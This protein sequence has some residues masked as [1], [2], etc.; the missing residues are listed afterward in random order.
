MNQDTLS[1]SCPTVSVASL[2]S[3]HF[4]LPSQRKLVDDDT[5]IAS[6]TQSSTDTES[7]MSSS[8]ASIQRDDDDHSLNH[9]IISSSTKC[10]RSRFRVRGVKRLI[11][12]LMH[13]HGGS[14]RHPRVAKLIEKLET[15]NP[16]EQ[17]AKSHLLL[18]D[19]VAH[20]SPD[21]PGRIRRRKTTSNNNNNNSSS[22]SGGSNDVGLDENTKDEDDRVVQYALGRLSFGI[23]QPNHLVC[24][25]RSVRNCIQI[26]DNEE[27]QEECGVR[28]RR[29]FHYPIIIDLTIHTPYGDLLAELRHEALC[30]ETPNNDTR[31]GVTFLGG[32]LEPAYAVWSDPHLLEL[33]KQTFANAYKIA[34]EQRSYMGWALWLM[35]QWWFKLSTP[36]DEDANN[37]HHHSVRF[38]MKRRPKGHLDV[39]YLDEEM[40]VTR[41]NR[42]TLI[43]VERMP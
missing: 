31:L 4:P 25:V 38:D 27:L 40:R 2:S 33:W 15:L 41:G 42:G 30:Y 17:P 21:F 20:S 39:L 16:T 12:T 7:T 28:H 5:L 37:S 10:E 24:T 3:Q 34:D 18:G 32:S 29:C 43:V 19:F 35:A 8:D 22:S 9:N 11:K 1:V 36:T 26:C 23:F 13:R 6:N 14:T